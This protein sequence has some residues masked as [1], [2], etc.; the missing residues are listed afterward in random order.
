MLG[1]NPKTIN[2]KPYAS[3]RILAGEILDGKEFYSFIELFRTLTKQKTSSVKKSYL[4]HKSWHSHIYP[5]VNREDISYMRGLS[6]T[7]EYLLENKQNILPLFAWK[8]SFSD[9]KNIWSTLIQ[10]QKFVKPINISD[11]IIYELSQCW[12][13]KNFQEYIEKKYF[14]IYTA[15]NDMES[16]PDFKKQKLREIVN[17]I[18]PYIHG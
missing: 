16:L 3:A 8:L 14:D 18:L 7:Q 17:I 1:E 15:F 5:W 4:R 9:A 11:Y 10:E 2:L 13:Y 12:K 6:E